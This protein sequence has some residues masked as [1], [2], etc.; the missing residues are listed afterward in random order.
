[1]KNG[2]FILG[3]A[4]GIYH[5]LDKLIHLIKSDETAGMPL[6]EHVALF[7]NDILLGSRTGLA[8]T[9]FPKIYFEIGVFLWAMFVVANVW[10]LIRRNRIVI[11][12]VIFLSISY[13]CYLA[14]TILWIL[15]EIGFDDLIY[16][17]LVFFPRLILVT[18]FLLYTIRLLRKKRSLWTG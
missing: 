14:I 11:T 18:L 7:T 15:T 5:M 12:I 4:L 16:F 9:G 17:S 2:I 6:N 3:L 10:S 8:P 1:M 13:V